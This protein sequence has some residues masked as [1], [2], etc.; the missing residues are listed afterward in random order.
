M[1]LRTGTIPIPIPQDAL[2]ALCQRHHIRRLALFGSALKGKLRTGSDV[3]L[4]VEFELG[5]VPGFLGLADIADEMSVLFGSRPIDLRTPN[6][7]SRYF[8]D[9][10]LREA[11]VLYQ[12][13]GDGSTPSPSGRGLG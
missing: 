3:D 6:D 9:E 2:A 11:A 13:C 8:R 12:G 5:H 7:L 4:L 1:D 10:V